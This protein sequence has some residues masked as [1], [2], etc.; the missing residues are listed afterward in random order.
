M[1]F[2]KFYLISLI[3]II[4]FN[5]DILSYVLGKLRV[6]TKCHQLEGSWAQPQDIE[7][8]LP[9]DLKSSF[10]IFEEDVTFL[11]ISSLEV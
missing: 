7:K 2:L 4:S 10:S 9:L 11:G 3:V 5:V 6:F 8:L 1:C